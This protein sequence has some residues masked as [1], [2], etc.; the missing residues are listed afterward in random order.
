MSIDMR[1]IMQEHEE[2]RRMDTLAVAEKLDQGLWNDHEII[3]V[4]RYS[5]RLLLPFDFACAQR[6]EVQG[7][8]VQEAMIAIH[9]VCSIYRTFHA[10]SHTLPL[11]AEATRP[12]AGV[13]GASTLR[14]GNACDAAPLW[15]YAA[16]A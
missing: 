9:K 3:S 7:T 14:E 10:R 5:L 13:G 2:A 12:R 16:G 1:R 8:Q 6:L 11:H 15:C 4:R